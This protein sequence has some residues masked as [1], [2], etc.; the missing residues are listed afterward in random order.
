MLSRVPAGKTTGRQMSRISRCSQNDDG[1]SVCP[2]VKRVDCDKTKER[3][4]QIVTQYDWSFSLVLLEEWLVGATPSTGNFWSTG[5]RCSEIADFQPIFARIASTVTPSE[6]SSINTNRKST[7]RF[8]MSLRWSPYVAPKPST[9]AQKRKMAV[10]RVKSHFAW[11]NS[12]TKFLYVKT[13]SDNAVRHKTRLNDHLS[14]GIR[15]WAQLLTIGTKIGDL[16]WR[17]GRYIALFH[18]IW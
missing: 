2:S 8:P 16:E 18:W 7:T 4:V 5:P 6:K 9:G 17:N 1:N 15:M 10:F 11:R 3:S 14:R 12:A 13:V